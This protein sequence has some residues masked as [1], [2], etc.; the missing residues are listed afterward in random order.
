MFQSQKYGFMAAMDGCGA[1]G[2]IGMGAGAGGISG[3]DA[4]A[5]VVDKRGTWDDCAFDGA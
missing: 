5:G 3:M 2:I 1:C 4:G